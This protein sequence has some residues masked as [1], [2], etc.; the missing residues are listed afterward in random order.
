MDEST[1]LADLKDAV[2]QFAAARHWEPYHT[3][4]NLAMSIAIEA[5]E[6]MEHF[7]WKTGAEGQEYMADDTQR[8]EAADEL[9]DILIYCLAFANQA[10]IDISTAVRAKLDRNEYRFPV[11][12]GNQ[13]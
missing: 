9:A 5:A 8:A 11:P 1:T 7:Q 13:P 2:R 6:L 12:P 3:S 10:G 4:K